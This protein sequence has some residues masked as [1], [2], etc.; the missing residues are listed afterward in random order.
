[1]AGLTGTKRKVAQHWGQA[2]LALPLQEGSAQTQDVSH[3]QR[4][5]VKLAP[6]HR[7]GP[8]APFIFPT[9]IPQLSQTANYK[10]AQVLT[11]A[12]RGLGARALMR[13]H[14]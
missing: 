14:A 9:E 10:A 11:K 12:R 5:V 1:M 3:V 2:H 7:K 6:I 4:N 8:P 13:G